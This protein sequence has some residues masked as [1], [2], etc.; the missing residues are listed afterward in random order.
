MIHRHHKLIFIISP[1]KMNISN[2]MQNVEA[3][4]D[5]NRILP[6]NFATFIFQKNKLRFVLVTEFMEC[7]LI[8]RQRPNI[9]CI[10]NS[11]PPPTPPKAVYRYIP[12]PD[13]T[14]HNGPQRSRKYISPNKKVQ[15][16]IT[17]PFKSK[18]RTYLMYSCP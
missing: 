2:C 3:V 9:M 5:E 13:E 14:D 11:N 18:R 7:S 16:S 15:S 1:F 4:S 17:L 10:F 6:S 8:Q 12:S